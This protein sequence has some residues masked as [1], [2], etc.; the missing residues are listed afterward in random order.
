MKQKLT[1]IILP[2]FMLTLMA[3]MSVKQIDSESSLGSYSISLNVKDISTSHAFYN[4]LGFTPIKGMG[5]IEQ[6][7]MIL[8]NGET[9]IG[10][11][12]GMFPSNTITFN[13]NDGRSIYQ[14]LKK[15]GIKPT[16]ESGM[17]KAEGPC[18][19]SITDPDGNPILIDQH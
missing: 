18:T 11:F 19:F 3:F 16:F 1:L 7:W 6:K 9:K 4:K 17:D 14:S 13:P 8:S 12:Q 5:S 2:L 10:L 15:E